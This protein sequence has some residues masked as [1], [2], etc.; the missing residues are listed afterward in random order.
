LGFNEA[1]EAAQEDFSDKLEYLYIDDA[2]YH[3]NFMLVMNPSFGPEALHNQLIN[4][5]GSSA[6]I[7]EENCCGA[8]FFSESDSDDEDEDEEEIEA[9]YSP[10]RDWMFK[11]EIYFSEDSIEF[12]KNGEY[13]F[14][15]AQ[16]SHMSMTSSYH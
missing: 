15:P 4:R 13:V 2:K 12:T 10:E 6:S 8:I 14:S 7:W 5:F 11:Y 1:S 3:I 9:D 16:I